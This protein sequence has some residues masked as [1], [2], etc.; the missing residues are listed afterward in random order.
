[1]TGKKTG[2]SAAT[3]ASKTL[4]DGRTSKDSKPAAG[5]ALSQVK[6][7]ETTGKA[8]AE[9]ASNVLQSASTGKTSKRA[10][11]SALSQKQ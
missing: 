8:A 4:R 11:G 6:A 3:A 1:M 10:A 7:G 9:A 2:K 5:S